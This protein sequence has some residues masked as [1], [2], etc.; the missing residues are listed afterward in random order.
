MRLKWKIVFLCS[1]L[2]RLEIHDAVMSILEQSKL[3]SLS[4]AMDEGYRI[5]TIDLE[6]ASPGI[7]DSVD[8]VIVYASRNLPAQ[9]TQV[10]GYACEVGD[11]DADMNGVGGVKVSLNS[12]QFLLILSYLKLKW[13]TCF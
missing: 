5:P 9:V 6:L 11:G 3:G 13:L 10:N 2:T 1:Q 12:T 7:S 4:I 8:D